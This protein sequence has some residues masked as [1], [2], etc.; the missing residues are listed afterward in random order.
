MDPRLNEGSGERSD[1]RLENCGRFPR[2]KISKSFL[3][4]LTNLQSAARS[5]LRVYSR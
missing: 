2:E 5:P 4:D 1:V 3:G